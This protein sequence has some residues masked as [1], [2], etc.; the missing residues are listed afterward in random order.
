MS[1]RPSWSRSATITVTREVDVHA[2]LLFASPRPRVSSNAISTSSDRQAGRRVRDSSPTSML[3]FE[4]VFIRAVAW[5]ERGRRSVPAAGLTSGR[6]RR[7]RRGE[8][9]MRTGGPTMTSKFDFGV[10]GSNG[11]TRCPNCLPTNRRAFEHVFEETRAATAQ[12]ARQ[13]LGDNSSIG[14]PSCRIGIGRPEK[15]GIA[16]RSASTPRCR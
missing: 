2:L 5:R 7:G 9:G 16:T 14:R 10:I 3:A 6:A 8:R 15:S 1:R 11:Q 4:R 12:L 13:P